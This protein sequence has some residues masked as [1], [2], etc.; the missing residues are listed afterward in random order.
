VS[1]EGPRESSPAPAARG[2]CVA[3][4]LGATGAAPA[5]SRRQTSSA[6]PSSIGAAARHRACAQIP[7]AVRRSPRR[8]RS[9]SSGS[10]SRSKMSAQHSAW[11]GAPGEV[12]ISSGVRRGSSS[13]P[14]SRA[15]EWRL[16]RGRG[17][18]RSSLTRRGCDGNTYWPFSARGRPSAAAAP[19]R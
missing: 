16:R 4:A 5:R 15:R 12:S 18:P 2:G 14:P 13:L 11:P 6:A 7:P 9:P 8:S 10:A 19:K 17:L 3:I 1:T